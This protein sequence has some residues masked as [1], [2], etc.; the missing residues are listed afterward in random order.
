MSFPCVRRLIET[1]SRQRQTQR[2]LLDWLRVEGPGKD[3]GRMQ[4]AKALRDECTRTIAPAR[5]L[6][7]ESLKLERLPSA[8]RGMQSAECPGE[9]D[10][11]CQT[12]PPRMPIPPPGSPKSER[13]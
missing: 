4:K 1:T 11:P 5:A 10:L 3:E 13:V 6:P 2:T 9:I 7:A 12:A 8:D